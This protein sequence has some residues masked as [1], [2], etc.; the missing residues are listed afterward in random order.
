M[1]NT[2]NHNDIIEALK[3]G[4]FPLHVGYYIFKISKENYL[5]VLESV[6]R[7]V[8]NFFCNEFEKHSEYKDKVKSLETDLRCFSNNS[9]PFLGFN[10]EWFASGSIIHSS[11]SFSKSQL[12]NIEAEIEYYKRLLDAPNQRVITFMGDKEAA[13]AWFGKDHSYDDLCSLKQTILL[14]FP[15]LMQQG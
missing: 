4:E 2:M 5:K 9:D 6:I 8:T 15:E 14:N 3:T 10:Q 12:E 13:F 11:C 1:N 7:H